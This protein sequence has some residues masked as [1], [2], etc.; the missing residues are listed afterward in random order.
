DTVWPVGTLERMPLTRDGDRLRG[1]GTFDMKA[2]IALA[3]AA[4]A[5]LDAPKTPRPPITMVWTTDEEIGSATS[6]ALVE[7]AARDAP[8]A[9][10]LESAPPGAAPRAA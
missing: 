1:P 9:L 10:V 7:R 8:A 2:G 5:A 3:M 6:R 4:I